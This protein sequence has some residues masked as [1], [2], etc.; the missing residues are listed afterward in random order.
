MRQLTHKTKE[1]LCI[2]ITAVCF[3]AILLI[4]ITLL[5]VIV[6]HSFG[7]FWTSPLQ[8]IKLKSGEKILGIIKKEEQDPAGNTKIQL[9]V[10]NRDFY[11]FDF[12]WI[13]KKDIASTILAKK[14]F[15]V[16]RAEYG[17]FYGFIT[18]TTP[19][20]LEK[21]FEKVK[22][23]L[24][25]KEQLSKKI[26][27]LNYSVKQKELEL[28]KEQ[29]YGEKNARSIAKLTQE[30]LA[31]EK[32][33]QETQLLQDNYSE[34]LA[35]FSMLLEEIGGEQKEI[36]L[37]NVVR[38]YNP[39]AMSWWDKILFYV[40][41]SWEFLSGNPREANTEGGIFPIIFGTVMLVI[42]MSIFCYPFGLAAAIYLSEYAKNGLLT[43]SV[44]IAVSNLAGVPSIVYGIFGLSFFIYGVGGFFDSVFFPERLP[45]PTFGTGGILWA[46][47]TLSILTLPVVIVATEEA[48]NA[49]PKG[50]KE[51]ALA[52][53]STSTQTL[54]RISLP[55][56]LP[57][58]IT[59]FVLA[60]ARAAGEVAP[61]L[62]TGVV[63]LAP[64]LPLDTD[65]PYIH[66]DRK[67]MHLGF[68][69]FDIA[70]Q[71]PNVE[72]SRPIVFVSTLLLLVIVVILCSFALVLR[73]KLRKKYKSHHI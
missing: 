55:V 68:H 23:L 5:S 20:K 28:I 17:D 10:G 47:L 71:S 25:E 36:L 21:E 27:S 29:Y 2:W 38:Y 8:S 69:I 70:F 37:E 73:E 12:R 30:K 65:F 14:V 6:F 58:I 54:F 57:G 50:M 26:N 34:K 32:E 11:G 33:F 63:K 42:I 61:L 4:A 22:K 7:V 1:L 31:L 64:A 16:E 53:G 48:L 13:D 49:V 15:L 9:K 41:K 3:S 51:G 60:I 44:R 43:R 59:G 45:T 56:A 19:E 46:S 72:A 39:N 40:E 18:Q 52:L 35:N 67:F 24:D 62:I 66:L